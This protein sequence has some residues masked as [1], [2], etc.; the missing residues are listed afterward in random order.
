MVQRA[1][2]RLCSLRTNHLALIETVGQAAFRLWVGN[3]WIGR[4]VAQ[5]IQRRHNRYQIRVANRASRQRRS[6]RIIV[7][8][9]RVRFRDKVGVALERAEEQSARSGRHHNCRNNRSPFGDLVAAFNFVICRNKASFWKH[10][11][12]KQTRQ[13]VGP[14]S[15]LPC[16]NGLTPNAKGTR[17]ADHQ[18]VDGRA[19]LC[20]RGKV[21]T[22]Q[23]LAVLIAVFL[24]HFVQE[25]TRDTADRGDLRWKPGNERT[26]LR[27]SFVLHPL[28]RLRVQAL[29][30]RGKLFVK[31]GDR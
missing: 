10:H 23:H 20:A 12:L 27:V 18:A 9:E 16:A 4:H 28:Q 6:R 7:C 21:N 11:T 31:A 25:H 29:Q 8:Y 15:A 13:E 1:A 22:T 19:F 24:E 3:S 17:H 5:E 2:V 26:T 30:E 14:P